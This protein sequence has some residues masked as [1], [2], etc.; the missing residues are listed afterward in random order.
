MLKIQPL[1]RDN[2]NIHKS[3]E[4]ENENEAR[5]NNKIKKINYNSL[6]NILFIIHII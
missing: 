6:F 5:L 2:N 1:Q 4:N 3:N